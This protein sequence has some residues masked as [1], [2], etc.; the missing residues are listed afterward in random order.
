MNVIDIEAEFSR[1]L[2]FQREANLDWSPLSKHVQWGIARV[3]FY[4]AQRELYE[5]QADGPCMAFIA[6]VVEAGDLIDL[7]AIDSITDHCGQRLGLGHGL[8]LDA[9]AKARMGYD[10]KLYGKPM[11][12]LIDPVDSVYLFNL[13]T[14]LTALDGV[15]EFTC[16]SIELTERVHALLPSSQRNRALAPP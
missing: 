5:L 11:E 1:A 9:I 16:S 12:W 15:G 13:D 4:G 10:L 7:C 3:G 2:R 14:V 6:P 8:G